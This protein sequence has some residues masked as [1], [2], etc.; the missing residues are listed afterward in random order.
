MR[1]QP[2]QQI[3][4]RFLRAKCAETPFGPRSSPESLTMNDQDAKEVPGALSKIPPNTRCRPL[5]N[6]IPGVLGHTAAVP[7]F[8]ATRRSDV[9]AFFVR[10]DLAKGQFAEPFT[11][12]NHHQPPQYYLTCNCYTRDPVEQPR[13][14]MTLPGKAI[15]KTPLRQARASLKKPASPRSPISP[16]CAA[17][18]RPY[19]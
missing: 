5:H 6:S 9:N 7:Q 19:P 10:E 15:A 17:D 4:M 1:S 2:H 3:A 12:E 16:G 14:R 8:P 11:A 13:R 18:R